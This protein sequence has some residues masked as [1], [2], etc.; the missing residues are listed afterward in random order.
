MKQILLLILFAFTSSLVLSQQS[1]FIVLKKKNNRTLRTYYPGAFISAVTNN[2]FEINGY[3]L[4]IRNDSLIIRQEDRRLMEAKDGM[5]T[6]VD[7]FVFTFGIDYHQIKQ[8]NFKKNY[9]WGGRKGFVQV[10]VPKIMMIGGAGFIALELINTIHRGDSL[11]DPG[12]LG[13]IGIAAGVALAGWLID[14]RKD[15][16]KKVGKKYKVV[17]VKAKNASARHERFIKPFLILQEWR[18][19]KRDWVAVYGNGQSDSSLSSFSPNYF[20]FFCSNG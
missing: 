4:D 9:T 13:A 12:K 6:V 11:D 10:F 15:R 17:Y 20:T 19:K 1:D 16:A 2:D 14:K 7:T 3:I 18:I 5:G 8:W